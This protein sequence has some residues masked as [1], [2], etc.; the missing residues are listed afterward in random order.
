MYIYILSR[1]LCSLT[2]LFLRFFPDESGCGHYSLSDSPPPHTL[3]RTVAGLNPHLYV[4]VSSW[5]KRI[6]RGLSRLSKGQNTTTASGASGLGGMAA[7]GLMKGGRLRAHLRPHLMQPC[8]QS[9][10]RRHAVDFC[11]LSLRLSFLQNRPICL[12]A[13]TGHREMISDI[14]ILY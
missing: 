11:K 5:G 8:P 9:G 6:E 2:I 1:A 7:D 12:C 4:Y 3:Q 14:S 10:K 13:H